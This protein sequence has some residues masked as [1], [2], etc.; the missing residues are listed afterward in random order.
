MQRPYLQ[1]EGETERNEMVPVV[2][3]GVCVQWVAST[4]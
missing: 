1:L 4:R 3:L 2:Y